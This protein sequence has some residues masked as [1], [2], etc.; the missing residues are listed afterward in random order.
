MDT[1]KQKT[2]KPPKNTKRSIAN[3]ALP[4]H[5]FQ[6]LSFVVLGP[7]INQSINQSNQ[8]NVL[9]YHAA[10]YASVCIFENK[11][12]KKVKKK[13]QMPSCRNMLNK[14]PPCLPTRNH[15]MQ[16]RYSSSPSRLSPCSYSA[17][18]SAPG[19]VPAVMGLCKIHPS[20]CH[21]W[22]HPSFSFSYADAHPETPQ[23]YTPQD[24]NPGCQS[25]RGS[26]HY[27]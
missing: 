10:S 14:S 18:C 8:S 24:G 9:L 1:K 26:I 15:T 5:A 25:G 22:W 27:F 19:I 11:P 7:C 3:N 13:V 2:C 23:D 4:C 12:K 6:P 16:S 20:Q 17:L 21:T